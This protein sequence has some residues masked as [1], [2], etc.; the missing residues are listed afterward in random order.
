MATHCSILAWT[1]PWTQEPDGLQSVRTD[2]ARHEQLST[3]QQREGIH[4]C[5]HCSNQLVTVV[6]ILPDSSSGFLNHVSEHRLMT[7]FGQPTFTRGLILA[8]LRRG[9]NRLAEVNML[10][11]F[12]WKS[13]AE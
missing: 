11:F 8:P 7:L 1:I 3:A 13:E 2:R 6:V 10:K 12:L 4:T 5:K 9:G